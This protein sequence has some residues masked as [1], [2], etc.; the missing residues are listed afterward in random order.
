LPCTAALYCFA[1]TASL[2]G[3]PLSEVEEAL[4]KQISHSNETTELHA[5]CSGF[6]TVK[7][8]AVLEMNDTKTGN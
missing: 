8:I 6:R 7:L 3:G 2:S 5:G 4:F 1:F